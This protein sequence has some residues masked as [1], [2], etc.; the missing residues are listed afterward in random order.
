MSFANS[1]S[2][3]SKLNSNAKKRGPSISDT[4]VSPFSKD[5]LAKIKHQISNTSSLGEE[6]QE[7]NP[8]NKFA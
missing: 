8:L 7:T 4:I 2:K 3:N 1:T 6:N 5:H